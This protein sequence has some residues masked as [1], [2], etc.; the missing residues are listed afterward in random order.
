MA[1]VGLFKAADE[2]M[3]QVARASAA[4]DAAVQLVRAGGRVAA[5]T[6]AKAG[7]VQQEAIEAADLPI[8]AALACCCSQLCGS[9]IPAVPAGKRLHNSPGCKRPRPFIFK[10]LD[11]RRRESPTRK[12]NTLH[13]RDPHAGHVRQ[14]PG[15]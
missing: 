9:A 4:L 8:A 6:A 1:E 5:C 3:V 2:A 12:Q 11:Q 7:I 13:E 10:P 14:A 15:V